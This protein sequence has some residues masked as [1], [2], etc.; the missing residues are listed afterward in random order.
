M[1]GFVR[2]VRCQQPV[3]VV[4]RRSLFFTNRARPGVVAHWVRGGGEVEAAA[5]A[6]HGGGVREPITTTI[7][8]PGSN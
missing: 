6:V 7:D 1:E 5:A 8:Y 3:V 4:G 2:W